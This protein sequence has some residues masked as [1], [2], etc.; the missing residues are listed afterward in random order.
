MA[1]IYIAPKDIHED[2][3]YTMNG[4]P[5][6]KYLLKNHNVNNLALPAK[7]IAPLLGVTIHNTSDL[8]NVEDDGRQYTAASING[9]MGD[10]FTNFYVDDLCAWQNL[11]LADMNWT[12]G[13]FSTGSGSKQTISIEIIMD[14]KTGEKNIKA[15]DN[16]A[17]IAAYLLFKNNMTA[18]NLFTHNYWLNIRNGVKGDYNKLCISPTPTRNCPAFIVH[19]WEGFRKQVDAYIVKLGGKSI[20]TQPVQPS[21]II[22]VDCEKKTPVKWIV[23]SLGT[24]AIRIGTDKSASIQGR[25]TKGG[26]YPIDLKIT[27]SSDE[28]WLKHAEKSLFS[29]YK[30]GAILFKKVG[31]FTV[32]KTTA[33]LNVRSL[34]SIGGNKIGVLNCGAS[35]Y[36]FNGSEKKSGEYTWVKML[37]NGIVGYAAK[38]YL[39]KC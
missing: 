28:L 6:K 15:R 18:N 5:I 34:P 25:V 30:D 17:R 23:E 8:P 36:V 38:E 2:S 3:T 39:K 4:V 27:K 1:K 12:C 29:M 31:D 10:C 35:V 33:K 7:R 26:L 37:W 22:N 32:Y 16:G 11:E 14:G 24:A 9:N 20:Y 21:P 13:D 19:D